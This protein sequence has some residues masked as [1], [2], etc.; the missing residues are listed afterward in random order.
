MRPGDDG[1]ELYVRM[2]AAMNGVKDA[3]WDALQRQTEQRAR[4]DA[5]CELADTLLDELACAAENR[6]VPPRD[7]LDAY[8]ERLDMLAGDAS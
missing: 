6:A 8:R 7:G 4:A 5:L 3:V 2:S 1:L